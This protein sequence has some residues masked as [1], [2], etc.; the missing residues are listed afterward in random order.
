MIKIGSDIWGFLE[1]RDSDKLWKCKS[2]IPDDRDYNWFALLAGVRNHI[3]IDPISNPRGSP[4]DVSVKVAKEIVHWGLEYA[5]SWLTY[6][7]F[8]DYNWNNVFYD[9]NVTVIDRETGKVVRYV[10]S[11]QRNCPDLYECRHLPHVSKDLITTEWAHFL[12]K[13]DSLS[14]K[15]GP[16]NVRIVFWFD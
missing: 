4:V 11:T 14:L 3:N 5:Y 2:K 6:E 8:L 7:D 16:E 1:I 12:N 15:Y 10:E 9:E 13:I